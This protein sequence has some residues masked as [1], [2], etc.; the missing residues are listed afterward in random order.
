LGREGA[1]GTA[2]DI[3]H[4]RIDRPSADRACYAYPM[5]RHIEFPPRAAILVLCAATLIGLVYAEGWIWPLKL[6]AVM[7][8]VSYLI[9]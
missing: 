6:A 3:L 4:R 1:R 2:C 9:G 7:I 8:P 5:R